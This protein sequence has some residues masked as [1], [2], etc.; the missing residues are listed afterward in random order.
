MGPQHISNKLRNYM[1]QMCS[2]S[3]EVA[4][5]FQDGGVY[6]ERVWHKCDKNALGV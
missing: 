3:G 5:K 6:H 1:A 4:S 2:C